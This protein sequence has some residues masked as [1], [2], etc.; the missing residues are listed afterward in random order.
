MITATLPF[1]IIAYL[2]GSISGAIIICRL[3]GMPD[4]RT[5]GSKN[6]GATNV[7]RTGS[8]KAGLMVLAFD[9][10]KGLVAVLL[11]SLF[12]M[13]G[14]LLG[15]VA[16]AA[17]VGHVYPVFFGFKGGKGVATALGALLVLSPI[18]GVL[19]ALTWIIVAALFRF[20][21]LAGIVSTIMAPIY[22]IFFTDMGYFMPVLGICL[23]LLWR[24]REN[25]KR[26]M[27]GAEK[28][29]AI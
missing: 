18:V 10:L 28:K 25:F 24:H 14:I 29:I 2:L 20:S 8:K 12:G 11:A 26:L 9:M 7:L 22:V 27:Q 16:A 13:E 15:L 6:P 19:V 4:P 5:Q 1:V 21:S 17:V 23:L 3:M